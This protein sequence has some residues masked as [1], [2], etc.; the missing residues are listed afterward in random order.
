VPL[1]TAPLLL[2]LLV[3]LPALYTCFMTLTLRY[4]PHYTPHYAT[5]YTTPLSIMTLQWIFVVTC[6]G[7]L[8]AL[9]WLCWKAYAPF[10]KIVNSKFVQG[11]VDGAASPQATASAPV[12]PLG[13]VSPKGSPTAASANSSKAALT[14]KKTNPY[15]TA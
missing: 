13:G 3:L 12:T 4:T 8:F 15:V 1:V 5:R 7:K 2:V 14:S 10:R 6:I 11:H 9:F